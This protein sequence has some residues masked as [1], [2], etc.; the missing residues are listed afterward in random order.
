M[1]HF[2]ARAFQPSGTL[3]HVLFVFSLILLT[4]AARGQ[5]P[6]EV[7]AVPPEQPVIQP[8][9]YWIVSTHHS[10]QSFDDCCPK[11][12]PAITRYDDCVGYRSQNLSNLCQS[13]EPGVPVC[14]MVHGS[15]VDWDSVCYESHCTWKWL[16][17]AACGHRMQM[18]YLTW[19]SDKS[20]V[21]PMVQ[22]DVNLLGRR[23]ARNGFYLADMVRHLPAECPVCLIG[24]SHGTRVISAGLHI[25]AGGSIQGVCCPELR[26][27]GRRIRTVFAASAVDHDWLNPDERYGRALCAT[28]CLLNLTNCHD[29][30]LKIYPL[31]RPLSARALGCTGFTR[32]D[33]DD[34]RGWSARA[35]DY[36]V[37][38]RVGHTH[39]W[40]HYFTDHGMA[41]LIHRFVYFSDGTQIAKR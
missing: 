8:N 34:L 13:L 28:E 1:T 19:P 14:I 16:H 27:G 29:P 38:D 30:A 22:L 17:N 23:A 37:S 35:I 41:Q 6:V 2:I 24:H 20:P 9:G 10:P 26:S 18:I 15:F 12:C 39:L 7:P 3:A 11:F 21:T 5:Q 31:R 33:R 25:M 32:R 4:D 36:D 40:P